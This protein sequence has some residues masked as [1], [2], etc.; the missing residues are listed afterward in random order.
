MADLKKGDRARVTYEGVYS[1]SGSVSGHY[2]EPSD[3]SE[4]WPFVPDG[5]T[6]EVIKPEGPE[7]PKAPGSVVEVRARRVCRVDGD[8]LPWK[9]AGGGSLDGEWYFSWTDL[10]ALGEVKVLFDPDAPA[11]NSDAHPPVRDQ[12]NDLW[13]WLDEGPSGP[14][15]YMDGRSNGLYRPTKERLDEAFGP[16]TQA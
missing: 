10:L 7:E 5:A 6:I 2:L 9:V 16:L 14:G 12:D 3:E 15:Y 4:C 11:V 8:H 13:A 1:H